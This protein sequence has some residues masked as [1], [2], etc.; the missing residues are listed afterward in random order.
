MNH[1][2]DNIKRIRKTSGVSQQELADMSGVSKAQISRLENGEQNN[3]QINTIVAI[4]SN[5][6]VSVE[7]II[8]GDKTES[9]S[10]LEKTLKELPIEDQESIKKLI[11]VWILMSQSEKL[12]DLE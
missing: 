6:G 8:Y 10:Y 11:K 9:F 2:G 1:L 5:L 4:A 12:K 7:E 3:P